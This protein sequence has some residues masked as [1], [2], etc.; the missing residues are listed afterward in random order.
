MLFKFRRGSQLIF[1]LKFINSFLNFFR[2]AQ[3]DYKNYLKGILNIS[4]LSTGRVEEDA[5]ELQKR[6]ERLISS[7]K[8]VYDKAC[9]G[10]IYF[11]CRK[12][13]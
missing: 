9:K 5:S 6:F 11:F 13:V 12:L 10:R 2:I 1:S 7:D 3:E 4:F 8:E